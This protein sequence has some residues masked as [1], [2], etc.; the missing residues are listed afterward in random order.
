M[1]TNNGA[2]RPSEGEKSRQRW[3]LKTLIEILPVII[4]LTAIFSY[5]TIK[6]ISGVSLVSPLRDVLGGVPIWVAGLMALVTVVG[7]LGMVWLIYIFSRAPVAP[8]GSDEE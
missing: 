8:D 4:A 1:N 7:G 5:T 6:N 2:S 3:P